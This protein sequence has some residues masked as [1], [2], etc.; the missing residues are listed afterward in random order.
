MY[1][2]QVFHP[3]YKQMNAKYCHVSL[4]IMQ[5]SGVLIYNFCNAAIR[6]AQQ[7]E[8]CLEHCVVFK[9]GNQAFLSLY[10]TY[11]MYSQNNEKGYTDIWNYH[12]ITQYTVYQNSKKFRF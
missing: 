1:F 11:L 4:I 2:A 8:N 12:L 3:R 9:I 7:V 10:Y 5:G 6:Y